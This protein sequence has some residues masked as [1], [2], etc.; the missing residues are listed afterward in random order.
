MRRRISRLLLCL[1]A[2]CLAVSL[3]ALGREL[4]RAQRA[5]AESRALLRELLPTHTP[6]ANERPA[7]AKDCMQD[8]ATTTHPKNTNAS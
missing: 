5:E 4:W 2:L 3:A 7:S 8:L 6:A 1:G